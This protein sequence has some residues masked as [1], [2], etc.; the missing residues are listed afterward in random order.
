MLTACYILFDDLLL[1]FQSGMDFGS[2][3]AQAHLSG[4]CSALIRLIEAGSTTTGERF[5]S[6]FEYYP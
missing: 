3:E 6:M 2:T 4:I 1:S 5:R